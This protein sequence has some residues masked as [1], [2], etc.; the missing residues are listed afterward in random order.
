M[1][2][3]TGFWVVLASSFVL[4]FSLL[5]GSNF[6]RILALGSVS[7]S[8]V[9]S[10]YDRKAARGDLR[11]LLG[12]ANASTCIMVALSYP[13]LSPAGI[14]A[15]L[16]ALLRIS[17][18]T[19][20]RRALAMFSALMMVILFGWAAFTPSILNVASYV[21]V[22]ILVAAAS[23][24]SLL[25]KKSIEKELLEAISELSRIR[26]ES[27]SASQNLFKLYEASRATA[28]EVEPGGIMDT[29]T[30]DARNLL[31]CE[32]A[33]VAVFIDRGLLACVTKGISNEFKRNLRWRVR[34]GGMTDWVLSSGKPLIINETLDDPRSCDSS[35]VRI[36]K[37]RSII[38]VP[39][40]SENEVFGIVYAGDS[41]PGRFSDHDL[42]LLTIIS[43]HAAAAIKQARLRGELNK[44]LE[45]LEGVHKELVAADRLKAEF[46]SSVTRQMRVPLDAVRTYSQTVLNRLDDSD[47]KLKRKFLSAIVDETKRLLT[48]VEGAIDLARMEFGEGDLRLEEVDIYNI[49]RD[50]C[51]VLE[52]LCVDREVEVIVEAPPGLIK[53][54]LDRDMIFLLYRNLLEATISLSKT[55]SR[56]SI[57]ISED[58]ALIET[59]IGFSPSPAKIEIEAA[60]NAIG[61]DD[62]IPPEAGPLGLS[63]QVA[64]NIV[65]RHGGRIWAHVSDPSLWSLVILFS[66]D[67]RQLGVSDVLFEILS[68]RPELRRMLELIADMISQVMRVNRCQIFLEDSLNGNLTIGASVNYQFSDGQVFRIKKNEGLTGKVYD[69]GNPVKLNCEAELAELGIGELLCFERMPCAAVP[70]R[71]KGKVTG[72]ITVS[73]K[74]ACW[75][76]FDDND[77]CLLTAIAE[78]IAV[79]LERANGYESAREQ[80]VAAMMAMRSV[81]EARKHKSGRGH[82]DRNLVVEL[83]RAMGLCEG[84]VRMLQYVSQIYDVGM[85][86]IGEGVLGRRGALRVGEYASV[87]RH[88]EVGVGIVEPI[89]FMEQVKE[90]MLRHHERYDGSGYPGGLRGEEI[91]IGARIL[92]V[93]DAYSSMV[94]ERPYRRAMSEVEAIEELRRCSGTQF[95]PIVVEKFIEIVAKRGACRASGEGK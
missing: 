52:P 4:V 19:S 59:R 32:S 62:V 55:S 71:I 91:P 95:D 94:S 65:L 92:A 23:F 14:C 24:L 79:A 12:G 83:G 1:Q 15:M 36:G 75:E 46:I 43:N 67:K 54:V 90:V 51:S 64:K 58:E 7:L 33:S 10:K 61:K 41:I 25:Q 76:I 13:L 42:M 70:I 5:Q 22:L 63:L 47:F 30:E 2:R 16:V 82:I 18:T 29:L 44:R 57:E 48:T 84:D 9:A 78:R 73:D 77:L 28:Q 86:G 93:V 81:L 88:P 39:L 17:Q 74:N 80:F 60:L 11:D 69:L 21:I 38:A 20:M 72:V 49:I 37:L 66:K 85:V 3:K 40:V 53:A 8:L 34:P 6:Q 89:E 45:E 50:A 35:A 31:G 68:S 26:R 56:M 27:E 87:K